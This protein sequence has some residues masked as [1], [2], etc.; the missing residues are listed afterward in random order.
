[1]EEWEKQKIIDSQLSKPVRNK[2][3][4]G[5]TNV[6]E[7]IKEDDGDGSSSYYSSDEADW[8]D[9]NYIEEQR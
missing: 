4:T 3:A 8:A 5:G 2:A 6:R 9:P 7:E 1:L